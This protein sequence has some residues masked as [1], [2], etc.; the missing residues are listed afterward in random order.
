LTQPA[1][2]VR[3]LICA[4]RG[5]DAP[6]IAE[7]LHKSG[8][9]SMT[10][11]SMEELCLE[12]EQGVGAVILTEEALNNGALAQLKFALASQEPWS[13]LPIVVLTSGGLEGTERTLMTVE[14]LDRGA[15]M[16][17]IERPLRVVTL[18]SVVHAALRTR[19]CQYEMRAMTGDLERRVVQRTADL[20]R[21]IDEAAGFSYT[22]S[23]DLRS[24]LRTVVATSNIL[25]EDFSE[26]LPQ[27][28]KEELVRQADAANTLAQLI[29]DLLHLSRLA[30]EE[31][32]NGKLDLSKMA[33]EIVAKM[34]TG[35]GAPCKFEIQPKMDGYGDAT[36]V[37]L[38]LLNLLQNACKF[39][40]KGGDVSV[41]QLPDG[42]Y[43]VKDEGIG[44]DQKYERKMFLPF[45]R[46]VTTA[47][48]PGTGIGLANVKRII[49]RHGGRAWAES[50][51]ANKGSCLHFTLPS[52]EA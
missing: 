9:D 21:L 19:K 33:A 5:R 23:H 8:I 39:S 38:A 36:L 44:F 46:L 35:P 29:D 32:H 28:A 18:V 40:P 10:V 1:K 14:R 47:E 41:G 31:M 45:E 50:A 12:A 22:I 26:V 7:T 34:P 43:F 4:P 42:S 30:R 17:L 20:Q 13:D 11:A 49:E 27:R 52:S 16:T 2:E 48:F 3:I 25:L 51:G 6:L 24:P 15:N 37:R